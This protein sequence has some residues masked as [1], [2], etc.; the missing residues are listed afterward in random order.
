[1]IKQLHH[2]A[3]RCRDSEQTRQFYEVFLGLRLAE[4]KL[5]EETIT[6]RPVR[7]LH[8]FYEMADGSYLAFFETPD[9]PFEFEEQHDF[10]LHVALEVER[11]TLEG[12]MEKARSAGIDV[13][14]ISDHQAMDSIYFRDP[15]GYV[16]EL[17]A[18]RPEHDEL[19]NPETNGAQDRLARWQEIKRAEA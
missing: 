11:D 6:G 7:A 8:T 9:V 14:G 19:M 16:V 10:D 3:C 2:Y 17:T 12:W 5:I 13:R 15:N 4:A 1:M 18:K